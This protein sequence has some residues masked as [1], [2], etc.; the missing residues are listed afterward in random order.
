M[1]A[2][3]TM[4]A[5]EA[6]RT[7]DGE[8]DAGKGME[9][10]LVEAAGRQAAVPLAE[11]L[12][13]EQL[14]VSRIEY[15]GFRPV[16]NFE[17]QLL[18]VEDSGGVLAAVQGDPRPRSLWWCAGKATGT[19]GSRFR[20]YWMWPRAATFRGRYQPANERCHAAQESC[21]R[22]SGFGWRASVAGNGERPR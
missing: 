5:E 18:P 21:N 12:R 13:I 22:R 7:A 15:I 1:K 6:T 11:V 3:V 9:Y 8:N 16:L 10:L 17:G 4:S 2:G 20:M 14:P 19:W